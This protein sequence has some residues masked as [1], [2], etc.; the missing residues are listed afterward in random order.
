METWKPVFV[1]D[2]YEVSTNGNVRRKNGKLLKPFLCNDY[3]AV[4]LYLD[5]KRFKRYPIHRLVLITFCNVENYEL[6]TVNHIDLNKTNN[7]ISNLEWLSFS[8]N[9]K[10]YFS[11]TQKCKYHNNRST[12]IYKKG[13]EHIRSKSCAAYGSNGEEIYRFSPISDC[14]KFGFNKSSVSK[15]CLGKEKSHKGYVWKYL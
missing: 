15:C 3:L 7:N 10:H 14:E 2:R 9:T 13:S 12:R 1:N 11:N 5:N 6:L 8:E 4:N